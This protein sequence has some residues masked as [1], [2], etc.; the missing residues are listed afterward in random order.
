[1]S[2]ARGADDGT[3]EVRDLVVR[4]GPAT[5]LDQVS[6]T[7]G[8]AEMVALIGPNG[9][10]KSTVVNTLSGV[11]KPSAGTVAVRGRLAHVPEGRQVFGDLTVEDNLRLGGRRYKLRDTG[12]VHAILPRLAELRHRRAGTLSGG[13]QQMVAVG[14]ALMSRPDVLAVDEL[15]LGLAPLVVADLVRHLRELNETRGLA[16]LLIEQ[17]ARLALDL[18]SRAY[19]LE[20]GRIVA[21]GPSEELAADD[22]VSAA[23]LGGVHD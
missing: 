9:A 10:G 5:A 21:E 16:V 18:C 2:G 3:V 4:Y 17:N 20:A 15:S 11:L 23:Y 1:M 8:P 7:V 14:R 6:L 19:V 13:E 22:R 12:P